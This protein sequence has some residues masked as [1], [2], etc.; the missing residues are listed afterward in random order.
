M[1]MPDHQITAKG[2]TMEYGY[3]PEALRFDARTQSWK[4]DAGFD[5]SWMMWHLETGEA[6]RTVAPEDWQGATD[7]LGSQAAQNHGD[8]PQARLRDAGG[9]LRAQGFLT[10]DLP[11]VLRR[12]GAPPIRLD[13]MEIDGILVLYVPSE[14]LEP[15]RRY[16]EQPVEIQPQTRVNPADVSPHGFFAAGTMIST[17]DGAQP[18]DWLRSG[19]MVLTRDNGYQPIL[20]FAQVS[21]QR[22]HAPEHAP[23]RLAAHAFGADMPE[24]ALTVT[25]GSQ[26]LL[27]DPQLD[28]WFGEAEMFA[29]A[30]QISSALCPRE[31][32]AAQTLT[33]IVFMEPEVILAEGLWVGSARA[34]PSFL[35]LLP[36]MRRELLAPVV[37]SR[38]RCAARACLKDWEMA[39]V[40]Q[41]TAVGARVC[42]A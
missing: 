24:R 35:S 32:G 34:T 9:A 13:R 8:M 21:L 31:A 12:S 20:H 25:A 26:I 19:D 6:G 18:V 2:P 15:G 23:L 28:L 4:L 3:P 10:G 22:G 11:L 17:K 39:L 38:H 41:Q 33:A 27:A 36:A 5:A 30:D 14:P 29:S 7:A 1:T 16:L 37:A 40:S 42:A